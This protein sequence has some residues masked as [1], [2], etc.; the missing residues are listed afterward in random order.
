MI[1]NHI[2]ISPCSVVALSVHAA[3][4][5]VWQHP[6]GIFSAFSQFGP[7]RTTWIRIFNFRAT[8]LLAVNQ[9]PVRV[10]RRIK[11]LLAQHG[12]WFS[13]PL[14]SLYTWPRIVGFRITGGR[15]VVWLLLFLYMKNNVFS[16]FLFSI[17][18]CTRVPF[19]VL[20]SRHSDANFPSI[21]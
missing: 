8:T 3:Q 15:G 20:Q 13:C 7:S 16:T 1:N 4:L 17:K 18:S 14:L 5:A 2:I 6:T 11:P 19:R 10:L 21:P 9:H 12:Q